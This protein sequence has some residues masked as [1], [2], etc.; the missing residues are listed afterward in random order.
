MYEHRKEFRVVKMCEVLKVSKSGYYKWIKTSK[1]NNLP[2]KQRKKRLMA[3]IRRL[4]FEY[5]SVY[6]SPRITRE[7][8]KL[9]IKIAERTVGKYM[10]EMGLRAT[11]K[12]KFVVTTDSKH[13]NPIY[14]NLLNR[15][16][17][18][19][20]P[21]SVWVTDITYIWT[22]QGWLYLAT[23]MDLFSRKII[24]WATDKTMT[25]ELPLR[26]LERAISS[27]KPGEGLIHHSDRGSQYTS[28][29]YIDRLKECNM[30]ISMSRKGNCYDNACME[31]FFSSLK[32]ELVYRQKFE[33][34][35]VA[36]KEIWKYIMSFYNARRSHST[37]G[38]VSPNEYEKLHG[39]KQKADKGE[40]A[41]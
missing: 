34:R 28:Q 31:S 16:F 23:V 29:D 26:A 12:K 41:A 11:P 32:K 14:P 7:L 21:N 3:K 24:G 35:E 27:R 33:N 22:M 9:G 37:L 17:E 15:Q 10:R 38:Y 4:F 6:G 1:E 13:Q 2:C 30:Q 5:R 20:K 25:K 18:V 8:W 39:N 36:A 19:D 40:S